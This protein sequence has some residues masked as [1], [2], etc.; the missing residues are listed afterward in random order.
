MAAAAAGTVN[1]ADGKTFDAKESPNEA[2]Q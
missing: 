2:P 1:T